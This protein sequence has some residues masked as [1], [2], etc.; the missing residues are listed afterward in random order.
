MLGVPGAI[1]AGVTQINIIVSQ[2]IASGAVA[3]LYYADRLYQLPLGVIG[4]AMGV[5]LLP[6]LSKRLRADDNQGAANAMNRAL[7][8]PWR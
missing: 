8:F 5:A 7:G 2:Q 6:A 4:I 3:L 1:A